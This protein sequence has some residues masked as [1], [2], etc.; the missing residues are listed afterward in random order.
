[1]EGSK[2]F[3]ARLYEE[4]AEKYRPEKTR[5]LFVA[6]APPECINRYF[7]FEDVRDHDSLWVELTKELFRDEWCG[8]TRSERKQKR[9]WLAKFRD[10]GYQLIDA[11]KEPLNCADPC[12]KIAENSRELILEIAKIGPS[13]IILIK[14]PVYDALFQDLRRANLPVVDGKLPFPGSG[15]QEEFHKRFPRKALGLG[16]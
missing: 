5:V 7:Y 14:H 9:I 8:P 16:V 4:A 6:A 2:T 3:N 10:A 15:W 13:R 11:V 12:K 1:M